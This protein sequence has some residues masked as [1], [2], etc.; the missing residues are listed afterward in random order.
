VLINAFSS[1]DNCNCCIVLINAFS[2]IDNCNVSSLSQ[3]IETLIVRCKHRD[4]VLPGDKRKRGGGKGRASSSSSVT[5]DGCD[6]TGPLGA[7]QAHL[8]GDCSHAPVACPLA[9]FGCGVRPERRALAAHTAEAALRHVELL[10]SQVAAQTFHL[11]RIDALNAAL[12]ARV[13]HLEQRCSAAAQAVLPGMNLS[14][15]L[16]P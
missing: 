1:I 3:V 8:D 9:A 2:S 13:G 6:W 15:N 4:A 11:G 14:C 5:E 7:R 16:P 12:S 10:V